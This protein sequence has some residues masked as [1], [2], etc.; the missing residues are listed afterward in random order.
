MELY[1]F[2]IGVLCMPLFI[3]LIYLRSK[4]LVKGYP[5]LCPGG[6]WPPILGVL[7]TFCIACFV[8]FILFPNSF[9][10][11]IFRLCG[12]FSL[13][14]GLL[15]GF[16]WHPRMAE[17]VH[18]WYWTN[19][20]VYE[21]AALLMMGVY[22]PGALKSISVT[23]EQQKHIDFF[24]SLNSGDISQIIFAY[25]PDDSITIT[26]MDKIN[27]FA[28]FLN[29]AKLIKLDESK[30]AKQIRI[31]IDTKEGL[32]DYKAFVPFNK[33]EDIFLE[34]S[35]NGS[36]ICIRLPGLKRWLDQNILKKKK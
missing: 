5:P 7:I 2:F 24:H 31:S 28:D 3:A 1:Y 35:S 36:D 27:E 15:V 13:A 34:P 29:N 10:S 18:K 19:F 26:N 17:E 11:D 12:P 22:A 20:V 30:N 32:F 21:Y 25:E 16:V 33:K 14:V 8:V 6:I 4:A 9:W 23:Y